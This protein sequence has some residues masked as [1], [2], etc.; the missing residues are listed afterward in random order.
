MRVLITGITGF[1]GSHLAEFLS[2]K[3]GVTLYGFARPGSPR[4]NLES[5]RRNIRLIRCDITQARSVQRALKKI[6]PHRIF[7]LAGQSF[8]PA[9]WKD[10][11]E[12]FLANVAGALNLLEAVRQARINPLIHMA[13]SSEE[14]GLISPKKA[15]IKETDVLKPLNPYGISK[16]AQELLA[17][18]YHEQ[19]KLKIVRT[20]AF[21]HIGPRQRQEFVA[22]SFAKQ[23]AEAEAG[24]G[25]PVLS[26]GNLEAVRDFT[27]VRDVVR[28][29]WLSL[30]KGKVGE[31]YNVCTGV[32]HSVKEIVA[33]YAAHS[34][35]R[36]R[37]QRDFR[38]SRSL[39]API[40]VGDGTKFK[41]RT[42]WTPAIPF[43][44]ALVDLLN[45]WRGKIG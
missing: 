14:Y 24:K 30:E 6:C 20:R 44:T 26:V 9:S 42:G 36:F 15:S 43:E 34:R 5:I 10:P 21:Q 39:D 13:G 8:V 38:R 31:V 40:V 12:T 1:V 27:D 29:Y 19:Y 3:K 17:R 18:Q 16:L 23:V 45:Y 41:R 11:E 22:S 37:V 33:L 25:R 4:H 2:E 7:H 28:A 35:V 32:G